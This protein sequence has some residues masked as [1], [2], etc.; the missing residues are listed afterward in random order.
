MNKWLVL[1]FV[2][3]LLFFSQVSFAQVVANNMIFEYHGSE[4]FSD[5]YYSK[6]W[7][8]F[9]GSAASKYGV[10]A[11]NQYYKIMDT[12]FS[13]NLDDDN[14]NWFAIRHLQNIYKVVMTFSPSGGKDVIFE[15][16]KNGVPCGANNGRVI[17]NLGWSNVV[18]SEFIGNCGLS[19]AANWIYNPLI[20][21]DVQIDA[22]FM[23]QDEFLGNLKR[24]VDY[25]SANNLE[26]VI[27]VTNSANQ[28]F[29]VIDLKNIND[30]LTNPG[31]GV[32]IHSTT[33]YFNKSDSTGKT[34][35]LV[36][37][38]NN[39]IV[40]FIFLKD[41]FT[42]E[43]AV[44]TPV[45]EVNISS[46]SNY[47]S[48]KSDAVLSWTPLVGRDV[49]DSLE[50]ILKWG[51]I[52]TTP[53]ALETGTAYLVGT[54]AMN[55]WA[56]GGGTSAAL[57]TTAATA[58]KVGV[59]VTGGVLSGTGGSM[60]VIGLTPVGWVII[61]V[62][63]AVATAYGV[64]H[65][66]TS[67]D[68]AYVSNSGAVLTMNYDPQFWSRAFGGAEAKVNFLSV[69][70]QGGVE[71]NVVPPAGSKRGS[72]FYRFNGEAISILNEKGISTNYNDILSS[73]RVNQGAVS[74]SVV[75][76]DGMETL[77]FS[78]VFSDTPYTVVFSFPGYNSITQTW[79]FSVGDLSE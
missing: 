15:V 25:V 68:V 75:Q 2:M 61:G 18:V 35:G 47:S 52:A 28:R 30:F 20:S 12:S 42:N 76:I 16:S 39:K 63:G 37:T 41:N 78:N 23:S 34:N 3:F 56:T 73:M 1:C 26:E 50:E 79:T 5:T 44:Y 4:W 14:E 62:A 22:V 45:T 27:N 13:Y 59:G 48:L 54:A 70:K 7:G 21:D 51:T 55:L 8:V 46:V 31:G 19:F 32:F 36:I 11:G 57:A 64:Y 72:F 38:E 69:I 33:Q 71:N 10:S 29:R 58:G 65:F 53:I 60:T 77:K 9:G 67:D 74:V 24:A 66:S 40:Y 43:W 49:P 6:S 17:K